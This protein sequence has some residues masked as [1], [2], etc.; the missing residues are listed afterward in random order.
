M[1]KNEVVDLSK[2]EMIQTDG[3]LYWGRILLVFAAID[4]YKAMTEGAS[5]AYEE[6][7]GGCSSS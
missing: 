1:S 7:C 3:G 4:A 6:K 2:S 5:E